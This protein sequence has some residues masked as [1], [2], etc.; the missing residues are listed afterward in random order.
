MSSR[1]NAITNNVINFANSQGC[2][3]WRNNI[4]G[5]FDQKKALEKIHDLIQFNRIF[6][7][8]TLDEFVKANIELVRALKE[9]Y[10][11]TNER[12][13]VSD[14]L[15]FSKTGRF[16]AIEIK[17]KGDKLDKDG[18]FNQ[19]NFLREVGQ[20]G[21]IAIIV[22]EQPEKIKLR[23]LGSENY[24]IVWSQDDFLKNFRSLAIA[25]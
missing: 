12:L 22:A 3:C 18:G 25:A 13:G 15:G 20:K 19:E 8:R 16:I 14:I 24:I 23:V 6:K 1:A 7:A 2:N 4:L 5:V 10:R 9:S 17:G 11:K 21:G